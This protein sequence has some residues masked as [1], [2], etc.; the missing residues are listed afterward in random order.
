[1]SW[2]R[3][4]GMTEEEQRRLLPPTGWRRFLES[5]YE[6]CLLL[7][8]LAVLGFLA[9]ALYDP[10][11]HAAQSFAECPLHITVDYDR[12]CVSMGIGR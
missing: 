7:V 10:V 6:L 1:M 5:V 11:V 12:H 8:G 9:V 4:E 3:Y 2:E